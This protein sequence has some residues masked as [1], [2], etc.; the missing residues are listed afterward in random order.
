MM[1]GIWDNLLKS[2]YFPMYESCCSNGARSYAKLCQQFISASLVLCERMGNHIFPL[3]Q[4]IY[5]SNKCGGTATKNQ[6]VLL[7][8]SHSRGF[9]PLSVDPFYGLA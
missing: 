6:P 4:Y 5:S 2:N 3:E 7:K 9:A 1:P 8:L